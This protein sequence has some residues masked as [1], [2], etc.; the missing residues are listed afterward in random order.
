MGIFVLGVLLGLLSHI[1][2]FAATEAPLGFSADIA[3]PSDW[4]AETD[5]LV[6]SDRATLTVDNLEWARFTDTNSMDPV[7]DDTANVLQKVPLQD[8]LSEGDIV[9]YRKTGAEY[10]TIHRIIAISE[11]ELG[12]YVVTKGDNNAEPDAAKVRFN[13]IEKVVVAIIY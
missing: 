10:L 12:W 5:I 2:V 6:Y 13:Q 4:V 11:D 1:P 7:F 3:S 9:S 8:E